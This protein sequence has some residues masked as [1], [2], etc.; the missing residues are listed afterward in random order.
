MR[1]ATH[2]VSAQPLWAWLTRPRHSTSLQG[3]AL[4]VWHWPPLVQA[5]LFNESVHTLQHLS[6][7]L[8]ALL[9]WWSILAP[10]A[11]RTALIA[12]ALALFVTTVHTS[13]LG[14]R[15]I[16]ARGFWYS[17]PYP[18]DILWAQ[19]R[20][21]PEI[22]RIGHVDTGQFHLFGRGFVCL[23]PALAASL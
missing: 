5:S 23:E 16:F 20:A 11:Q 8:A 2:S 17:A 1:Q 6:F 15:V 18:G 9:F 21:R 14:E 3:L 4:W 22:G 10:H 7:L 13:L 12:P 19:S